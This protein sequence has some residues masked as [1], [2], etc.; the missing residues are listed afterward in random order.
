MKATWDSKLKQYFEKQKG[1]NIEKTACLYVSKDTKFDKFSRVT[2]N[3]SE[4]FNWL[5]KNLTN[6]REGTIDCV[7]LHLSKTESLYEMAIMKS[8]V[9]CLTYQTKLKR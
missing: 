8:Q 7:V 9:L 6:W 2:T 5:M 1:P 3:Q 4:G